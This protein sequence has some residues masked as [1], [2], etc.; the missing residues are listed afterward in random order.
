[1]IW[2]PEFNLHLAGSI[3]PAV[4]RAALTHSV[5]RLR[6]K[7]QCN[8][9]LHSS[10]SGQLPDLGSWVAMRPIDDSHDEASTIP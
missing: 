4:G 6:C 2:L 5:N 10:R 1:M 7:N 9:T 3:N 8:N